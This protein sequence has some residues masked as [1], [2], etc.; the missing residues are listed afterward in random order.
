[1]RF[2]FFIRGV[3]AAADRALRVPLNADL[4]GMGL[5]TVPYKETAGQQPAIVDQVLDHLGGL[6]HPDQPGSDTNN[7]EDFLWRCLWEDT[8]QAR[9]HIGNDRGGL[10]VQPADGA[11]E[12]RDLLMYRG[13]VEQVTGREVIHSVDYPAGTANEPCHVRLIDGRINNLHGDVGIDLPQFLRCRSGLL[14]PD[15]PVIMEDLPVEVGQ[16]DYIHIDNRERADA[17]YSKIDGDGRA[18]S[19]GPGYK[20]LRFFQFLLPFFPE[21]Q[22]LALVPVEFTL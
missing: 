7:R 20:D 11:V 4:F 15:I 22:D 1:N 6:D 12:E 18:K 14:L 5:K 10:P 8:L 13:L 3:A 21:E 16:F 19:A 2:R 17:S 9:G